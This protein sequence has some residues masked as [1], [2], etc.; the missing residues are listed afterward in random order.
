MRLRRSMPDYFTFAV[1]RRREV[2][3]DWPEPTVSFHLTAEVGGEVFD[4][5]IIDVGFGEAGGWQ[6]ETVTSH[7]MMFAGIEPV[8]IPVLPLEIQ[9]AVKLH[10][11]SRPSGPHKRASTRAKDLIDLVLIV[12]SGSLRAE[13]L[14]RSLEHVFRRRRTHDLPGSLPSPPPEWTIAYRTMAQEVGVDPD[15]MHGR[16]TVALCLDAALDGRAVGRWNPVTQAWER[17]RQT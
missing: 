6:R 5:A 10:A 9:V 15:P 1:R 12:Q 17:Q 11:Y 8:S 2:A 13:L 14:R 3:P 7:L 4:E 16:R